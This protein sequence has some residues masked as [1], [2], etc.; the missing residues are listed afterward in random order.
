MPKGISRFVKPRPGHPPSDA[1]NV[2]FAAKNG[3]KV[4][5]GRERERETRK[6]VRGREYEQ[7]RRYIYFARTR[8][9]EDL[10]GGQISRRRRGCGQEMGTIRSYTPEGTERRAENSWSYL[11][12]FQRASLVYL[13]TGGGRG[14]EG[15]RY[16]VERQPGSPTGS[17]L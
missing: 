14:D 16:V 12:V 9:R 6:R 5:E 4:V 3:A 13:A 10:L 15:S 2:A 7:R 1:Y 17:R 11:A 8:E